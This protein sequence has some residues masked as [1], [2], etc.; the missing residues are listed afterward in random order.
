M[1]LHRVYNRKTRHLESEVSAN[2][3]GLSFLYG[4]LAGKII[5]PF[6]TRHVISSTYGKFVKSRRSRNKIKT[7]VQQYQIDLSEVKRPLESFT[8]L[9]NFFIRELKSTARP[10]DREPSHL[11]SPADARLLVFNLSDQTSLPVKGYWIS[12][13][14]FVANTKLSKDYADGW[15]FVY[16]LAPCDYH[17]FC[18][19]DDGMQDAVHR[20]KGVLHSVNPIALSS[21]N[22]LM[23]K[24]YRELTIM[25]TANFG[26]VL[27]FEVGALMVGRVILHN[28]HATSFLKGEEKGFFEFGGS[29]IIQLFS[30]DVIT[31]D[32][33]ILDQSCKGIETLIRMGEKTGSRIAVIQQT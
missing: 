13:S 30:K 11:I 25:H 12:L 14:D 1:K 18:Y 7:F 21:V 10:V 6:I 27:H 22:A 15:C 26:R 8:S 17:R 31:P 24:N 32:K 33:D 23:A 5:N 4:S 20:I 19:V 2:I 16:R 29:T 3:N 9:N 28:R